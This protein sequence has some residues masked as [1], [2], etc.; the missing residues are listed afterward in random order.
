MFVF[1]LFFLHTATGTKAGFFFFQAEDGIRDVAVTGVQTCA[2]PI[3]GPLPLCP[4]S[5]LLRP[6]WRQAARGSAEIGHR[7]VIQAP[8]LGA[9]E[10]CAMNL[11]IM[12]GPPSG[13]CCRISHAACRV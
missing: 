10:S 9:F 7:P 2:L 4:E 3:S 1:R 8:K 5:R 13:R 6:G 11:P 12:S